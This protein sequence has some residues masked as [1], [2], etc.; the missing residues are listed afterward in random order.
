MTSL[1]EEATAEHEGVSFI[2]NRPSGPKFLSII[3]E[4]IA[5]E[6]GPWSQVAPL[7]AGTESMP[8]T[9]THAW[10]PDCYST[11]PTMHIDRPVETSVFPYSVLLPPSYVVST[12][13]CRSHSPTQHDHRQSPVL[14]PKTYM[15]RPPLVAVGLQATMSTSKYTNPTQRHLID[16]LYDGM[17]NTTLQPHSGRLT[18]TAVTQLAMNRAAV[19]KPAVIPRGPMRGPQ[20]RLKTG[21]WSDHTLKSTIAVV[22]ASGR[23][24]TIARYFNILPSSL[25]DHFHG[26]TLGRKEA[27]PIFLRQ[28]R[29]MH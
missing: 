20:H 4:G 7:A 22:E 15:L 13:Q 26:R 10:W 5:P 2:A 6:R 3:P 23:V 18:E 8:R 14:R 9:Y 24:K 29:R 16:H 1:Q 28:M 12:E 11:Q 25:T 21:N 17:T 19:T 27:P